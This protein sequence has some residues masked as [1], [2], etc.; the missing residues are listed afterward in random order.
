M[1]KYRKGLTMKKPFLF[2]TLLFGSLLYAD[3][4]HTFYDFN[5]TTI[6]GKVQ[7]MSE[8]KGKVLLVVNVAS[9]CGFTHQYEGLERLYKTYGEKGFEI[10]AFPSNEFKNQEPGTNSEIQTFC[11]I[12]YG[13]TFPLFAKIKVNGD[14]AHPLYKYLKN[15]AKGFLGSK[16]IK[17]NFTKFLI[18]REGKVIDRYSSITKPS[19]IEKDI[20]K[21]L[22]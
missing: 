16:S 11:E 6:T 15:E 7:S 9:K 20:K 22:K 5:A 14:H 4:S 10:L 13:I 19:E 1:L 3:S 17:W 8:Y 18:N 21:V 2:L 12:N